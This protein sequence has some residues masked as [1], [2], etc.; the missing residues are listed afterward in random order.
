MGQPNT[1][2][3]YILMEILSLSCKRKEEKEKILM[4]D[5]VLSIQ[6]RDNKKGLWIEYS[7]EDPKAYALI[8]YRI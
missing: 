3:S 7:K 4:K 6:G 8:R 2:P 5:L 1:R